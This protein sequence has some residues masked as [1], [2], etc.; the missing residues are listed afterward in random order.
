MTAR[1][2]ILFALTL[3]LF[4]QGC[5][6]AQTMDNAPQIMEATSTLQRPT[7]TI[8]ST[9][10]PTPTLVPAVTEVSP[11]PL[12]GVTITAAK[13]NLYIRRGP[14]L[15]Y[16]QI[17]VLHKGESANVIGQ[18]VLS[19]WVQVQIPGSDATGW[20]SIMTDFSSIEG[21]LSAVP[22]FTFTDWP[23]PAYVKNC[24]EH[25]ILLEPGEIYLYSARTNA[26]YLNEAQVDPGVYTAFDLF[27]PGE[28]EIQKVEIRE[29]MYV[30]LTLNGLGVNHKCP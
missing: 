3:I 11:T 18:D 24:T 16:N 27:V 5:F 29:G 10:P 15:P 20:V 2:R 26:D 9:P 22:D 4:L 7:A 8:T 19:R 12:P 13:G 28:P 14:G 23:Q 6:R 17:G 1:K 30:Y 25:D 21:D